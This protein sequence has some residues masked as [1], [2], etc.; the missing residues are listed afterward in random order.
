MTTRRPFRDIFYATEAEITAID[1]VALA[2]KLFIATDSDKAYYIDESGAAQ[3]IV[4][5]GAGSTNLS[6]GTTTSTTVDI[7]SDTGTNATIPAATG[8]DA[9]LLTAANWTKLDGIETGAEVNNISDANATDLTDAGDSTLHYHASDRNRSNHTGTQSISTIDIDADIVPDS[10]YDLGS[11]A[12]YFAEGYVTTLFV[13]TV[14]GRNYNTDGFKLDG[15]E[16]GAEVNNISDANA[17]DLTDSGDTTLHYHA[18][19]RD[20]K[21]HT[22]TQ[23]A[24]TISDFDTEVSNNASVTANTAKTGAYDVPYICYRNNT[25][26]TTAIGATPKELV[27]N[28]S[29]HTTGTGDFTVS[30]NEITVKNAGT[31]WCYYKAVMNDTSSSGRGTCECYLEVHDGISWA[32]IT[33]SRGTGYI[34]GTGDSD[35]CDAGITKTFAANDKIRIMAVRTNGAST[36]IYQEDNMTVLTLR[37]WE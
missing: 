15:I 2:G 27:V 5:G 31:Y 32:E 18:D 17:T 19:D 24:A 22:G 30:G 12:N 1:S 33:G 23:T 14:N 7:D 20:R 29:V 25:S 8:S 9:G 21:N 11:L 28:T 10:S 26:N 36:A 13:S 37:R 3:I 4:G 34:R 16:S 35:T 6:I